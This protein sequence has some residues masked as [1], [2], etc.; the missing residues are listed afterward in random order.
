MLKAFRY[1][2]FISPV[3]VWL[4]YFLFLQKPE[5]IFFAPVLVILF[6]FISL[7]QIAW[8][9]LSKK[10]FAIISI[11]PILFQVAL[12]S[13]IS[14]ERSVLVNNAFLI[15]NSILLYYYYYSL[16]MF[17]LF[18]ERRDG[19][20]ENIYSFGNFILIFMAL[21]SIYAL[22]ILLNLPVW[23][24]I[25][26]ILLVL[27][28]VLFSVFWVNHIDFSSSVFYILLITLVGIEL[29]WSL[30]FLPLSYN[31]LGLIF[32]IFYYMAV[33]LSRHHLL[34]RLNYQLVKM[35]LILGFS[36]IILIMFTARWMGAVA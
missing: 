11:L 15:L 1:F 36:S 21:S 18:P 27:V 35:Y 10:Y 16:Y 25:F 14:I 2:K 4:L 9:K 24:L 8:D 23:V 13:H 26:F 20:L 3:L 28:M 19:S 32:A 33:G 6:I 5:F 17:A 7:W 12:V 34:N 29:A 22:Q 31:A 30:S